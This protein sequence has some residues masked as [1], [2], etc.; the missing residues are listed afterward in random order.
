MRKVTKVTNPISDVAYLSTAN[1]GKSQIK[2]PFL[3][4][5][6][7]KDPLKEAKIKSGFDRFLWSCKSSF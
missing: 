6:K 7:G 5:P 3:D 1:S 2:T 4:S